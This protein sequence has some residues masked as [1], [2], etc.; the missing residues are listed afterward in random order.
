MKSLRSERHAFCGESQEDLELYVSACLA[1]PCALRQAAR[2][3]VQKSLQEPHILSGWFLLAELTRQFLK[4][5]KLN[6]SNTR[7]VVRVSSRFRRTIPSGFHSTYE[8]ARYLLWTNLPSLM[9]RTKVNTCLTKTC[10]GSFSFYIYMSIVI[11]Q[12]YVHRDT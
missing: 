7:T 11:Y 4:P 2:T 3:A 1:V 6:S 12:I 8:G 10:I 9:W 5:T